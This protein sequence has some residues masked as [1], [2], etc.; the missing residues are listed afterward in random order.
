VIDKSPLIDENSDLKERSVNKKYHEKIFRM[1]DMRKSPKI[2]KPEGTVRV[3]FTL[4]FRSNKRISKKKKG[5][6]IKIYEWLREKNRGA[7]YYQRRLKA[8]RGPVA[9]RDREKNGDENFP[10]G[11][12]RGGGSSSARKVRAT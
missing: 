1:G 5:R 7:H 12:S 8:W 10:V 2:R 11:R 9:G 4:D 6:G 3:L